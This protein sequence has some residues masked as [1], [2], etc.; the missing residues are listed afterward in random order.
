MPAWKVLLVFS[1]LSGC[2]ASEQQ[3]DN[4]NSAWGACIADVVARMD[5]GKT[6]PVSLAY[7]IAPQCAVAYQ[8]LS[9]AEV[10]RY[11]TENG[12]AAQRQLWRDK[13]VQMITSAVLIHRTKGKASAPA[14][15]AR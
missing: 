7:G 6:D 5:D 3:V 15:P 8:R 12:Q 11:I 2:A 13:E 1:L 4:L 9:E 10:S 14:L